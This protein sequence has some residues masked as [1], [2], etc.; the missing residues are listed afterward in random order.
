MILHFI[1]SVFTSYL[2][3]SSIVFD[4]NPESNIQHWR[5]V[6]DGVMGGKS[7]GSMGINPDG[8]GIFEGEVSLQNNGGFS[9]VKYTFDAFST[10]HHTQ[11][12]LKLKGDGKKYQFRIKSRA[13]DRHSYVAHF[14]S[15]GEWEEI[16]IPLADMYPSFRGNRLA[17]PHFESSSFEE[18]GFLIGNKKEEHFRLIIDRIELR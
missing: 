17:L 13:K 2:M 3:V 12:V 14:E 10:Q 15:S 8:H 1:Y 18:I 16:V 5:V 11:I 9:S 7:S 4:F 6:D